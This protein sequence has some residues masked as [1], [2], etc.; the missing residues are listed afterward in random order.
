MQR[1][2]AVVVGAL[3]LLVIGALVL[4]GGRRSFVT[5]APIDAGADAG[6]LGAASRQA[7][8]LVEGGILDDPLFALDNGALDP[9]VAAAGSVAPGTPLPPG[10][11][12]MVRFGVIVIQYRGAEGAPPSARSRDDALVLARSIADA[13]HTDFKAQVSRGDPGSMEDAGRIPRG[14]LEPASEYALFTLAGGG[15][16][17]PVDTPRGYWIIK[18]IE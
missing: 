9:K 5:D 1:M 2:T 4:K 7:G 14:V 13:A 3:L 17:D 15:V 16:S 12:K 18:R 11:P 6:V 10:T 8:L